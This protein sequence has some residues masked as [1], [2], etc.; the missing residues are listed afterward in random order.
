MWIDSHCHLDASEFGGKSLPLAE[1][2]ARM[3]VS[4]IVIPA[5]HRDR[6]SVV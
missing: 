1:E 3:G 4:A 2:A 5:V 6:K